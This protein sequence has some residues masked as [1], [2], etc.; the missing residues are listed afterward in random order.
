MF[1][2]RKFTKITD[3]HS[4]KTHTH[5][6]S[7]APVFET[8]GEIVSPCV[9]IMLLHSLCFVMRLRLETRLAQPVGIIA[10]YVWMKN[11]NGII[12]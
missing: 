4:H 3:K 6:H 11:E 5:I 7:F 10:F 1:G 9:S 12:L 8:V 2:E